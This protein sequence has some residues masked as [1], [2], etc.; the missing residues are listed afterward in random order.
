MKQYV[1]DAT[2]MKIGCFVAQGID[3]LYCK[4]STLIYTPQDLRHQDI[5]EHIAK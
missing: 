2:L 1:V 3:T 4:L 5:A